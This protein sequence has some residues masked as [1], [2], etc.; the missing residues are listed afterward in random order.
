M[1][2]QESL[3]LNNR[4]TE[5]YEVG[6]KL[7]INSDEFP[8]GE[9]NQSVDIL[10]YELIFIT[11]IQTDKPKYK[12][13]DTIKMRLFFT[14]FDGSAANKTDIQNFHVEIRNAYDEV[15]EAF[16]EDNFTPKVYTYIYNFTDEAT[17]GNYKIHVWTNMEVDQTDQ[18][19]YDAESCNEID[20]DD[21][22]EECY[23][24]MKKMQ[25][26]FKGPFDVKQS[27]S[28]NFTVEKY[29]LTEFMLNVETERIVRPHKEINVKIS[30]VYS[31]GRNVIGRASVHAEVENERNKGK[32]YDAL[33]VVG[34]NQEPHALVSI[35]TENHLGLKDVNKD[36]NV[37]LTIVFIDD[38][39]K[40]RVTKMLKVTVT[41]SD[42]VILVMNPVEKYLK[43]GERFKMSVHLEDNDGHL[44][45]STNS[46]VFMSVKKRYKT[47]RCDPIT[48]DM[49]NWN[50]ITIDS[51][52]IKN[53]VASFETDVSYNTTSME[54]EASY[55]N[56]IKRIVKNL[57]VFISKKFLKIL[58]TAST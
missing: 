50:N 49:L 5:M 33:I 53:F 40:Q 1:N 56:G 4:G 9:I 12:P 36:Y 6:S 45:E 57:K 14:H 31:F 3:N 17:E 38:L 27:H 58:T 48:V 26:I 25:V 44:I 32:T 11:V 46:S 35:H 52:H 2:P 19:N 42:K 16:S 23:G 41:K 15:L 7:N 21:Y 55:G 37:D 34:K 30:G 10:S 51:Q 28:Q 29:V 22:R 24:N 8:S 13:G 54:F 39:S 47:A 43:P 20:D 18:P